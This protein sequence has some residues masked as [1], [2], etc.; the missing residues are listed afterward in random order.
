MRNRP[1]T[2]QTMVSHASARQACTLRP[3]NRP[4]PAMK[5]ALILLRCDDRL[6]GAERYTIDLAA[7][8]TAR[9]IAV[10]VLATG[11]HGLAGANALSVPTR[12]LT[13]A[14][15][16][17]SFDRAVTQLVQQHRFDLVHAMLPVTTCDLYHP[18]AGLETMALARLPAW[19]RPLLRKR[20]LFARVERNLI[21]HGVTM[22]A[23]NQRQQREAIE[24]LGAQPAKVH[25]VHNG[26]DLLRFAAPAASQRQTARTRLGLT[27]SQ[28]MILFVG[29]DF[30]RKGLDRLILALT[31]LQ[32]PRL[33]LH[34]VGSGAA[35]AAPFAT[36]HGAQRDILPW[37]HAADMLVLPS[38]A[39]P[40]PLVAL[41][42]MACGIPTILSDAC[43]TAEAMTDGLHGSI[44]S[45]TN[46]PQPWMRAIAHWAAP[47][48]RLA[49]QTALASHRAALSNEA[50]VDQ[51]LAHYHTILQR[52]GRG[53][54]G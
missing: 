54:P 43:G 49:A 47:T 10:S 30:A 22:L 35:I 41:E 9:G 24:L 14:A 13:R 21:A 34:I 45:N 2:T 19:R 31:R 40:F 44:V 25:V 15:R 11:F 48:N 7:G 1:V 20:Q 42:A 17:R 50:H 28:V 3:D 8:L 26:I 33:R 4:N 29:Q 39:D 6:G 32:D 53:Q 18:H 51:I 36:Y 37:L 12:G 16:Y 38:R 46:D 27:D 5:L 23:L 52:K